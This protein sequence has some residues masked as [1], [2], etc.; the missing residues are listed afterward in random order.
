MV[1]YNLLKSD[2]RK[3]FRVISDASCWKA[4]VISI[5][6]GNVVRP[7]NE[8]GFDWYPVCL[9]NFQHWSH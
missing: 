6:Y 2:E 5:I 4:E 3:L 7:T 1:K 9:I 8:S